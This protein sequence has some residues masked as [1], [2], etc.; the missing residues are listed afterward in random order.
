EDDSFTLE[1]LGLGIKE[2]INSITNLNIAELG[3][4]RKETEK[5]EQQKLRV[6]TAVRSCAQGNKGEK[7]FVKDYIKDLLQENFSIN[8][9]TI[10]NVIPFNQPNL[11]TAQ[12]KFEI[13]YTQLNRKYKLKAFEELNS[14][15]NLDREKKDNE[16]GSY[17]EVTSEDIHELYA[18]V[19]T[20]L[21]Y[22]D[23]LEVVTQRIYQEIY[24]FSVADI[25]R[26]D[27]TI[28]G[29][30]G[31]CS[32]VSS[33]QYNYLE[34]VYEN[35]GVKK[36]KAFNSL[37]IFYHGKAIHLSFLSFRSQNDLIRTCKNLYRYGT[38]GHITSKNGSKL[39]YQYD[40]SR[41]VVLRP[42]LVT[43]WA[44]F[45]RKFDSAKN[46]TINELINCDEV[47]EVLKWV[48]KG[49]LNAIISGDPN[50][51]KTTCLRALTVF[52]D[53]RN[54][55]RTTEPEFELWLNNLYDNLNCLCFRGSDPEAI[56]A[57]IAIEKKTDGAIMLLG[58][59][60]IRE[61]AA[62]YISLCQSGT[63]ATVCTI[64][65]V[66]TE[67]AIDYFRNSTM[68]TGVFRNE[69]TA[70][71][72]AANSIHIDIHWEKMPDGSRFISYINEIVPF[73]RE[74]GDRLG[75]TPIESIALSL[76]LSTRKRAFSVRPII[77]YEDGKYVSKNKFSER[78][79]KRVLKNLSEE[80][81]E[82]FIA[83]NAEN[84]AAV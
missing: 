78:L 66:S 12:E 10:C 8:E 4:S 2:N 1:N 73:P 75:L 83:F 34:E 16:F 45:V 14:L 7:D 62:E 70:E 36:A 20:P 23:G 21:S 13:L 51:G 6:S 5:R 61:L 76:E 74:I 80:D 64:H 77:V 53:R 9:R 26:D 39:S 58:E 60:N 43:H 59:V 56:A 71:E 63:K 84:E 28:D 67:D 3:L 17:Y 79:C 42:N 50:S 69:M 32:G 37:W 35:G 18:K 68:S 25:L 52:F 44:F 29:I 40:G 41:V 22:V 38:V 81:K 31:G 65:T 11:L 47:V 30:S 24:G 57:A 48:I 72:Q 46:M 55:I 49:C 82:K 27:I 54:P 19:A 33:E 15:G